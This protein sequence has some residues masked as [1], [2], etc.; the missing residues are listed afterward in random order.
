MPQQ[1]HFLVGVL[2]S[3]AALGEWGVLELEPQGTVAAQSF[4]H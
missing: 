2:R 3:Q 1:R 4:E